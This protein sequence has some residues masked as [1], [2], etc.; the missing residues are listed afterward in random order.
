MIL[1]GDKQTERGRLRR[2]SLP[3]HFYTGRNGAGKS[4]AAVFDTMPTLDAG[5]PVLSTV[6]LLDYTDPRDCVTADGCDRPEWH[7][8]D[9]AIAHRVAHPLYVPFTRWEQLLAWSSGDVLMD[10]VTGVADSNEGAALPAAVGNFLAQMRRAD[11]A[12]RITGLSWIRANKRLREA[13][14][15]VTRC[16]AS[17]P[18]RMPENPT[19][20]DRVW[21]PRRLAKWVTYDAQ[22]LPM[23][24]HT[25]HAYEEASVLAKA[26][27]W[28]PTSAALAAYDTYAPVLSIGT[29]TD[30]GRCAHCGGNRR[31][32]ECSCH[33]YVTDRAMRKAAAPQP[34]RSRAR[35]GGARLD[36]RRVVEAG[37]AHA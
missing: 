21:R 34:E 37:H 4:L 14:V 16:R 32:P 12:V 5:R 30:A 25:E 26:R 9:N 1:V 10:E 15:A 31:A 13:V 17:L 20:R 27:H 24:D 36:G 28:I 19:E 8:P 22:E 33:D 6:R 23:D 29:V 35:S 11:V 3:I 7:D 2:R 18:V